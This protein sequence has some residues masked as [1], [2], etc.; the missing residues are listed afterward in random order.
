MKRRLAVLT[1]ATALLA[2]CGGGTSSTAPSTTT[3]SP[4]TTTAPPPTTAA[5]ATPPTLAV[6]TRLVE[7]SVPGRS[8]SILVP[9]NWQFSQIGTDPNNLVWQWSDPNN[10]ARTLRIAESTCSACVHDPTTGAPAPER[11]L[12]PADGTPM[13]HRINSHKIAFS[14][15]TPQSPYP[16]NGVVIIRP[17]GYIQADLWLPESE[18]HMATVMLNSFKAG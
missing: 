2:A 14:R 10:P 4:A 13:I 15:T 12:N 9:R 18:H 8:F 7:T 3:T 5:T 16:D 17:V 6:D 1:C 11:A